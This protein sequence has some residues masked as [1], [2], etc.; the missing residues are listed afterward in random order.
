L[1]TIKHRIMRKLGLLSLLLVI[2]L[3]TARAQDPDKGDRRMERVRALK[4]GV[5]TEQLQLTPEEA[6]RFWPL[7]NQYEAQIRA[8][9][10]QKERPKPEL[11]NDA[12]L[13][14]FIEQLFKREEKKLALRRQLYRDLRQFLPLRKIALLP[15]AER[16]FKRQLLNRVRDRRGGPMRKHRR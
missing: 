12:Q 5:I 9:K 10:P 2:G 4:V 1:N 15:R 3:I 13:E 14:E 11:M 7:Y 6:G 8:L 16:R